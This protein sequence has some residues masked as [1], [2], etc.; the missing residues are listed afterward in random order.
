MKFTP[1][2]RLLAATAVTLA[3]LA[4]QAQCDNSCL[5]T[6]SYCTLEADAHRF[7]DALVLVQALMGLSTRRC[8]V[9]CRMLR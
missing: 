1:S 3:I 6:V 2:G 4:G 5:L 8:G 9:G 7:D